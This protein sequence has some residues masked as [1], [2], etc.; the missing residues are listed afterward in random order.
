MT[1][2][3]SKQFSAG[4]I[5]FNPRR[6]N[7]DEAKAH[8]IPE[9]LR[10]HL[11][12][13]RQY[14]LNISFHFADN[15]DVSWFS[16]EQPWFFHSVMSDEK[17]LARLQ[18]SDVLILSGSGMSAY[19]FQE[20]TKGAF[21][22]EDRASLEKTQELVKTHFGEGKWVLGICFGGQLAVQVVGGRIGRLPEGVTEAGL[23][24]HELKP[25]AKND[26][27]FNFM[28]DK[29][30]APHLHNDFVESLPATGTKVQTANGD[31]T[32][33]KAEVLAVRKGHLDKDGLKNPDTEYIM[34]S[35]IEF[36]NGAKLYQIQPHP[37]MATPSKANFL[38]RMNGWLRQEMGEQ[39]YQQ[40]LKV[41]M[42]TDFSIASVIPNFIKE[43]KRDSEER[44]GLTFIASVIAQNLYQYMLE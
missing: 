37:E 20:R 21:S 31:I 29:F 34:A 14:P 12:D 28:P 19:H 25:A 6:M 5:D 30:V 8:G 16:A 11:A 2:Q 13:W 39:Y 33:T 22:P 4:I 23:L 24:E 36:D 42:H 26:P 9:Q 38:V 7:P 1:T 32:V 15:N 35:V 43:A 3:E 41:P 10:E 18:E 17:R 40:A 44:R 27:V